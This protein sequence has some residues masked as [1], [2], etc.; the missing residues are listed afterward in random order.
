MPD[1]ESSY[2]SQSQVWDG[3]PAPPRG[4]RPARLPPP[5]L[6]DAFAAAEM[7]RPPGRRRRTNG[8][9]PYSLDW[10]ETV[11]RNRY[12][13][14]GAWIPRLFEFTKHA[15]ETVLGLGDVLGTDWVRLARHGCGVIA[16]S[17]SAD[18]LALCKRNF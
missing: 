8:P 11:E 17:S 1:M 12:A 15:G 18:H 4:E 14:Y 3:R 6:A 13:R 5:E 2:H 10:F 16:C 9:E 7:L